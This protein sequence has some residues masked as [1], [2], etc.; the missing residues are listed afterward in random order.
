MA[1]LEKSNQPHLRLGP[2]WWSGIGPYL[3]WPYSLA[4]L[5]LAVVRPVGTE[6]QLGELTLKLHHVAAFAVHVVLAWW[7]TT[8]TRAGSF[9]GKGWSFRP[10][11]RY[12]SAGAVV[13]SLLFGVFIEVVQIPLP[14]RSARVSD[15]LSNVLGITGGIVL[16][17]LG[18]RV[19]PWLRPKLGLTARSWL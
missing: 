3:I 4:L 10:G 12:S 15:L 9:G 17:W 1:D 7:W 8:R 16:L 14:Y 5:I 19:W 18:L 2:G 11:S 13:F 6:V